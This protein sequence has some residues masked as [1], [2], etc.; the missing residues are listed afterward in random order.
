MR[1]RLIWLV[2]SAS[3]ACGVTAPA[4]FASPT[5][6]A[7]QT[8]TQQPVATVPVVSP[9]LS[10]QPGRFQ[11]GVQIYWH[12]NSP[13]SAVTQAA[14]NVLNYVVSLNANS[15]GISFPIYTDGP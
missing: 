13:A 14:S 4:A 1:N 7:T 8:A 6:M 3:L 10:W 2:C 5:R 12:T 9:A 11:T 15:V